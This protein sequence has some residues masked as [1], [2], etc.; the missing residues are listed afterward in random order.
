MVDQ[1]L[2]MSLPYS[3]NAKHNNNLSVQGSSYYPKENS[4][5]LKDN[6]KE[7]NKGLSFSNYFI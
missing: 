7:F 5:D 2:Q 1:I 3:E 4:V 6:N